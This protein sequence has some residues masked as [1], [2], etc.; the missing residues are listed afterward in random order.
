MEYYR[1]AVKAGQKYR[2][3]F[4]FYQENEGGGVS[5]AT[6]DRQ[7]SDPESLKNKIQDA[8]VIVFVGG[9]SPSLEGEEMPVSVPGFNKGDR[10]DIR[11][12]EVQTNILKELRA[13]G[14]PI[15][16][17]VLTGSALAINW[18]NEHL[19]AVLNAWYGGQDAGTALADVLFGDYN[20]AGRLPVTFY[21]SAADLPPYEDYG[22]HNRTYRYFTG[23]PLY[24]FGYGLSYTT[25]TYNNLDVPQEIAIGSSAEISVDVTNSG[26]KDGE[27][28]VQLY[29]SHPDMKSRAP[30]HSLQ[31]FRRVWLKSGE[32]RR[33]TF[34]L[35]PENM[36]VIDALAQ[37]CVVPG[38]MIIS[39]GGGQPDATTLKNRQSVQGRSVLKGKKLISE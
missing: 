4:E 3:R 37:R 9:I 12:P 29:L 32:T 11:L 14:K 19:P 20:P 15:V 28:V 35:R 21:K 23:E 10:T 36:S 39:L 5:L 38:Q 17:V 24:K 25:F 30:I 31:G 22:M 27:E 7:K 26:P 2:I 16:F 8:D 18:E 34:T 33:I 1:L 6:V 13:T